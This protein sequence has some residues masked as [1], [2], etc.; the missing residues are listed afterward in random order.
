MFHIGRSGAPPL[1]LDS[2]E[3]F[4]LSLRPSRIQRIL[5]C[6]HKVSFIHYHVAITDCVRNRCFGVFH[7][8]A[9]DSLARTCLKPGATGIANQ[10]IACES[11]SLGPA[12]RTNTCPHGDHPIQFVCHSNYVATCCLQ[13]E[14]GIPILLDLAY[15]DRNFITIHLRINPLCIYRSGWLRSRCYCRCCYRCRCRSRCHCFSRCRCYGR[16]RR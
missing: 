6:G 4:P 15:R 7:A 11:E 3:F 13:L 10:N 5:V 14:A 2:L 16:Y 1:L 12:W 9:A 8:R